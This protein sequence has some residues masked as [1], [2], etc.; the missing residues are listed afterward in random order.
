MFGPIY[1]SLDDVLKGKLTAVVPR[2]ASNWWVE[3]V[4]ENAD[5]DRD[6]FETWR[7]MSLWTACVMPAVLREFDADSVI[8]NIQF[9]VSVG[10]FARTRGSLSDFDSRK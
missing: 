9:T 7:A 4:D 6:V 10:A 1:G 8:E 5:R 2:E 3:L